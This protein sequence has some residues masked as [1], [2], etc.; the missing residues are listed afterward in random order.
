MAKIQSYSSVTVTDYSDVGTLSLYLS[1][2]QPQH[3]IYDPNQNTYTPDWGSSNLILTP[4][5]SYDGADVPLNSPGLVVSFTRQEGSGT[6]TAITTGETVVGNTLK[7]SS[8]K[9]ASVTSK[10]LVYICDVTYTKPDV[11]I[12]V[13]LQTTL[14]FSLNSNAI[15]LKYASIT[16]DSVFLYNTDQQLIGSDTITLTANLTNVSVSQWQYK[17]ADGSWAVFPSTN[18]TSVKGTTIKVVATES[19][20]W[21]NNSCNVKLVTNDSGAY[22]IH[23]VVKIHDGAAG[24]DNISA[25]L[26]NENHLVP[27]T[28]TGSV[29]SWVGSETEI[30]IYEGN[31]DI[32]TD[33]LISVTKG[34]GLSGTYDTTTH[35]FAPSALTVDASY[36]EFTCTRVGYANIVKRYTITKQYAG[37]DGDDAVIYQIQPSSLS[38][39]VSETGVF[40]PSNVTF[41]GYKKVGAE[42]SKTSYSGRFVI[43]ESTDGTTFSL[44][45]TSGSD[46]ISKTYTPSTNQIKAIRC[47]LY[48]AGG[49]TTQLDEQ[50]VVIT[51]DGK[52][53]VGGDGENGVSVVLG[54]GTEVIPCNS[55]GNSIVAKDISIPFYGFDGI[56]RS[57][58]TCTVGTLPSGVTVK[59][60][61]PGTASAGGLLVLT[62][63]NGATFGNS[64]LLSGD[65]TLT[66]VCKG[67]SIEQKFTWTKNLKATNG[68]NAVLFQLYSP[69]GGTIYN[70]EG[71][72]TISTQLTSGASTVTPSKFVW[73]KYTVGKGYV[74]IS[75]QTGA[76]LIV[77]ADM[78]DSTSWFKCV[79]TYNGVEYT[80]YWTVIDKSDPV[81]SFTFTTVPQFKNGQGCGAVYTRVYRNG[82]E[83]DPLRSLVF[84]ETAPAA[85]QT[86][87]FYYSLNKSNKTC[88]LKKYSGSAWNN[89]SETDELNYDYYRINSSGVELDTIPFKTIR[90]FYTDPSIVSGS[91]QFR[92]H[93]YNDEAAVASTML[94]TDENN[95]GLTDDGDGLTS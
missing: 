28:S 52:T 72:T 49:T 63:A 78:V 62:V 17:K 59:S 10:L 65:I 44:K 92:C 71:T 9:L 39:N 3:V 58:V 64:S 42:L 83:L 30:H 54:N 32:T 74:A 31:E 73:S 68:T 86:G 82:E 20:I 41:Y 88:I 18:N 48:A 53:V 94:L 34:T 27:V 15:E 37:V 36:A 14:T 66:L 93:V 55:A 19:A 85:P 56:A 87:D 12:P 51:K 40:S 79:A 67:M 60:N 16:G 26:S 46:E 4:C 21:V 8:N 77:T 23:T 90:C 43:S 13:S 69:D 70:G 1:S 50:T 61:T 5:I 89:A 75:G 57:P 80:A 6:A 84:S 45:Y 29:K 22:D 95:N 33:W 91:M 7:V 25:V 47:I 35:I 11:N 81:T 2:N 76:S 38:L 24:T